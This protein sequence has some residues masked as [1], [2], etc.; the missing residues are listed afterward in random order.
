M[1]TPLDQTVIGVPARR[2]HHRRPRIDS[3][4][5]GLFHGR[6]KRLDIGGRGGGRD[7]RQK[8]ETEFYFGDTFDASWAYVNYFI[9]ARNLKPSMLNVFCGNTNNAK[10]NQGCLIK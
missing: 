5:H 7:G 6:L 2:R 10:Q 9:E 4:Y 8:Q 3:V 1:E